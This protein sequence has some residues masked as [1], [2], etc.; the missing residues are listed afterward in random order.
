MPACAV[1]GRGTGVAVSSILADRG[2]LSSRRKSLGAPMVG[3]RPW[4]KGAR[5]DWREETC[6]AVR[7]RSADGREVERARVRVKILRPDACVDTLGE[8]TGGGGGGSG[9]GGRDK[10]YVPRLCASNA[11][12]IGEAQTALV[13]SQLSSVGCRETIV[14]LPFCIPRNPGTMDGQRRLGYEVGLPYMEDC[15]LRPR[16]DV[17]IAP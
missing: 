16:A 9:G 14:A 5:E 12:V 15:C 4:A 1:D 13:E 17:Y 6:D 8:R 3:R 10:V 11:W 7:G 2:P